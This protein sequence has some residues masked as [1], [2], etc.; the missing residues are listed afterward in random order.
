MTQ[1]TWQSDEKPPKF[2][3]LTEDVNAEVAIVGGGLAGILSAYLLMKEG[4]D[5]VLLEKDIVGEGVT[6]L[7]TAFLTSSIDTDFVDLIKDFGLKGAKTAIR[8][9]EEA[10]DLIERI[11]KDEGVE[12]DFM[13]CSNYIYANDEKEAESLPD[14]F[15]AMTKIGLKGRLDMRNFE[16]IGIPNAGFIEIFNQAKFHPLKFLHALARIL[17]EK[18]V[19]IFGKSRVKRVKQEG[20]ICIVETVG[21]KVIADKVLVATYEPFNKP[22]SLYFKKGR[23]ITY[24]IEAEIKNLDLPEATYEDTD[25]PY[26]YM[27]V[28][29]DKGKL[30]VIVGGED[31]RKDIHV[32]PGRNFN[33]LREYMDT[34]LGRQNYKIKRRWSGPILEP[35]DGLASIGPI[36]KGE[37][38]SY[39]IGFSGNGMTYSGITAMVFRNFVLGK[40]SDISRLYDADRWPPLKALATKGKD[41]AE[42]LVKGAVVNTLKQKKKFEDNG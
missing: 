2:K 18:G 21:N 40:E 20:D 32:S 7:T 35:V 4:R 23:Y 30:T 34:I 27:R 33:A 8:S 10:I 26:H 24:I 42:E 41:Y 38:I 5:V 6:S 14:E 11:A 31:H 15:D 37:N 9:H 25:N 19:R 22:L 13:R 17:D 3:R 29:N 16:S 36:K 1:T 39:C 12:C 28:D